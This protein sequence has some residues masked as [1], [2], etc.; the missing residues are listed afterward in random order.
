[1]HQLSNP[2]TYLDMW[3]AQSIAS[4]I[5][6]FCTGTGQGATRG[7]LILLSSLINEGLQPYTKANYK[8]ALRRWLDCIFNPANAPTLPAVA[9]SVPVQPELVGALTQS[10]LT[11]WSPDST[12][13]TRSM[14]LLA[15]LSAWSIC[16]WDWA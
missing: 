11:R 14:R 10:K 8:I 1:M 7:G 13:F 12:R 16:G 2:G 3:S 9:L 6:Q 4:T 15:S 5:A